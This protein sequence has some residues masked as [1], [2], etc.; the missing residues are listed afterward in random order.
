MLP[1]GQQS[2]GQTGSDWVPTRVLLVHR[3][4]EPE[5]V[6]LLARAGHDVLAVRDDER[7]IRFLGVFQAELVLVATDDPATT[8]RAIRRAAAGISI[9]VP[10]QSLDSRVAALDAGAE[11]CLGTPFHRQELAARMRAAQRRRQ[12]RRGAGGR[13][14]GL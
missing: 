3:R 8:C 5:L 4:P 9:L 11:D 14:D 13:A 2:G 7:P 1:Q 6:R 10:T 12:R